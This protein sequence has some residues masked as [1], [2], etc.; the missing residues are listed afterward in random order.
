MKMT[1]EKKLLARVA[2]LASTFIVLV[3]TVNMFFGVLLYGVQQDNK[4]IAEEAA[5]KS[6]WTDELKGQYEDADLWIKTSDRLTVQACRIFSGDIVTAVMII[7]GMCGI[8]LGYI[9]LRFLKMDLKMVLK[10]WNRK[11]RA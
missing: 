11:R 5:N 1:N 8:F 10:K 2:C 9:T 4:K 6:G 3:S 7:F